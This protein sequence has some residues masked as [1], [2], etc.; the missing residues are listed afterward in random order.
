MDKGREAGVVLSLKSESTTQGW[1]SAFTQERS[2]FMLTEE[3]SF[4]EQVVLVVLFF[5]SRKLTK[6][7]AFLAAGGCGRP[8]SRERDLALMYVSHLD[9]RLARLDRAAGWRATA[10]LCPSLS[11]LDKEDLS[12]QPL[13]LPMGLKLTGVLALQPPK[14][15]VSVDA[16]VAAVRAFRGCLAASNNYL[17]LS[18]L[19]LTVYYKL[20]WPLPSVLIALCQSPSLSL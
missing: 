14:L 5:V 10:K 12:F 13:L 4:S 11:L 6:L 16:D 17:K 9:L 3:R 2:A 8:F 20:L 1:C 7:D 19:S 18:C 15:T